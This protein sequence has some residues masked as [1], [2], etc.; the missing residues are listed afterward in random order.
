MNK[1]LTGT[2]EELKIEDWIW[3]IYL[4]ITIFA[5]ISNIFERDFIIYKNKLSQKAY[6]TI[7]IAIFIIVF[8]IYFYFVL[9]TYKRLKSIDNKIT[10]KDMIIKNANFIAACLFLIGGLL[11]LFTE[12]ISTTD[13]DVNLS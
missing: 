12:L 3:I 1:T 2:L 11:Y 9:L 5:L 8:F 6:K 4:F 10:Y 7:N 13:F